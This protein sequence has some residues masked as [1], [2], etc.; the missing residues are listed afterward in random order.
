[1][2]PAQV[3]SHFFRLT[4]AVI[5]RSSQVIGGFAIFLLSSYLYGPEGRGII[6]FLTSFYM[7][8]GLVIS[9]GLGRVAYQIISSN[10]DKAREV[11][12]TLIRYTNLIAILAIVI[13]TIGILLKERVSPDSTSLSPWYFLLV[14]GML[15]YYTW[16]NF[17]NYLFGSTQQTVLHE[18]VIFITRFSQVVILGLSA[19]ARIPISYFILLFGITAYLIFFV[20]SKLL[21]NSQKEISATDFKQSKEILKSLLLQAKWPFIDSLALSSAPFALFLLGLYV[22]H[23]ELGHFNFAMQLMAALGFP[24]GVLQVKLQE[25]LAHGAS[26]DKKIIKKYFAMVFPISVALIAMAL[27]VPVIL[28]YVGLKSFQESMPM[29]KIQ[30]LSIPI[31]GLLSIFQGLWVGKHR[32]RLSS[33]INLIIGVINITTVLLLSSNLGVYAGIAGIYLSL[34]TGLVLQLI[35]LKMNWSNLQG[36]QPSKV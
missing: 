26:D 1:M 35:A 3:R 29:L 31:I 16:Y 5:L 9:L 36:H 34:G 21:L 13:S 25:S 20:E 30:L 7:T 14:V 33:I 8:L 6:S 28:P 27:I 32:A 19:L 11:F 23:N 4:F 22:S 12:L 18:R 2:V 24:F 10:K 17:S 15:P